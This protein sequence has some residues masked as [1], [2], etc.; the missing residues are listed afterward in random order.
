MREAFGFLSPSRFATAMHLYPAPLP[1]P[2]LC[3]SC[4]QRGHEIVKNESLLTVSLT[5][6][7][8][9]QKPTG[10]ACNNASLSNAEACAPSRG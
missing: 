4:G 5:F 10:S 8:F 7:I 6:H 1:R 9:W 2:Q 3:A